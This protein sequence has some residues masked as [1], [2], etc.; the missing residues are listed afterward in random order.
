MSWISP[1]SSP[2]RVKPPPS[3][4]RVRPPPSPPFA[5]Q[6]FEF[7][8]VSRTKPD[9]QRTPG[10]SNRPTSP[11]P[12]TS[13]SDRRPPAGE[14][15]FVSDTSPLRIRPASPT[16][17]GVASSL[18]RPSNFEDR[19]ATPPETRPRSTSPRRKKV[20]ESVPNSPLKSSPWEAAAAASSHPT[21]PTSGRVSPVNRKKVDDGS[22]SPLKSPFEKTPWEAASSRVPLENQ[23]RLNDRSSSPTPR[24]K[25]QG[26][27][28]D[29]PAVSTRKNANLHQSPNKTNSSD[30]LSRSPSAAS[31]FSWFTSDEYDLTQRDPQ[32]DPPRGINSNNERD[33]SVKARYQTPDHQKKSSTFKEMDQSPSPALRNVPSPAPSNSVRE[34]AKYMEE[35]AKS[36]AQNRD[37]SFS[38]VKT[39]IAPLVRNQEASQTKKVIPQQ[40]KNETARTAVRPASPSRVRPSS[41]NGRK[42]PVQSEGLKV[43]AGTS[44]SPSPCRDHPFTSTG[45][46]ASPVQEKSK[47][48]RTEN[49]PPSPSRNVLPLSGRKS[50][51][52][53][54]S[55]VRAD[56]RSP[57]PRRDRPSVQN[58]RASANQGVIRTETRPSSPTRDRPSTPTGRA[59]PV[60]DKLMIRANTKSP[61]HYRDDVLSAARISPGRE[62]STV[63]AE[64]R[65][66]SPGRDIVLSP[67]S[68]ALLLKQ[69]MPL[70]SVPNHLRTLHPTEDESIPYTPQFE[71]SFSMFGPNS[72]YQESMRAQAMYRP[73]ISSPNSNNTGNVDVS[74]HSTMSSMHSTTST[75]S[76]GTVVVRPQTNSSASHT[77]VVT[78]RAPSPKLGKTPLLPPPKSPSFSIV[79]YSPE[80]P[81]PAPTAMVAEGHYGI[82][83]QLAHEN[84]DEYYRRNSMASS[85]RSTASSYMSAIDTGGPENEQD[86]F[87]LSRNST[88]RSGVS[89]SPSSSWVSRESS[90]RSNVSSYMMPTNRPEAGVAT[91]LLASGGGGRVAR[92]AREDE[93][94]R[95]SSNST[96]STSSSILSRAQSLMSSHSDDTARSFSG[97]SGMSMNSVQTH[98]TAAEESVRNSPVLGSSEFKPGSLLGR[99]GSG[100]GGNP[101]SIRGPSPKQVYSNRSF[102]GEQHPDHEH[103]DHFKH[104]ERVEEGQPLIIDDS[105]PQAP[106]PRFYE[107]DFNHMTDPDPGPLGFKRPTKAP[108]TA[109]EKLLYDSLLLDIFFCYIFVIFLIA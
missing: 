27:P 78:A 109:L 66:P 41:P 100:G 12:T 17:N 62:T 58:G 4:S 88:Y 13:R 91:H 68:K 7:A 20:G 23:N 3:P 93:W 75:S 107:L 48:A 52:Q 72:E 2:S 37:Y 102:H 9:S 28:T 105:V 63:R 106:L 5:S 26:L 39:I 35:L 42:S 50:P 56:T 108:T 18:T 59:S 55:L 89:T 81:S 71:K 86:M 53:Q 77:V 6:K 22:R 69:A 74:R 104:T 45:G 65:P 1:S 36:P 51:V 95:T 30:S 90:M 21:T 87:G 98:L 11:L 47:A 29:S 31:A 43:S 25:A 57:S 10:L 24:H 40:E 38:S 76:V 99:N 82:N 94:A 85:I 92:G 33:G 79:S 61:S 14:K 32:L 84:G 101:G 16:R 19:P 67:T 54:L 70:S 83:A 49:R 64:T 44:R 80:S 96:Q 8:E 46:R 15:S 60:Q 73:T 97:S 34:T 103:T